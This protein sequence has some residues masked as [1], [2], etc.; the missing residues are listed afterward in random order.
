MDF[1]FGE[2]LRAVIEVWEAV[3]S[4]GD[5][6]VGFSNDAADE[7]D[8]GNQAEAASRSEGVE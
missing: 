7:D 4:G 6:I 2:V 8:L 3:Y 1:E 5:H